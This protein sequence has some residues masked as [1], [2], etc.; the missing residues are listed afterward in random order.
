[1]RTQN[2]NARLYV[3]L[4]GDR[5][6]TVVYLHG[7][8]SSARTWS[9]LPTG[10]TAGRVTMRVD[11]RGH[12]RSDRSSRYDV[13]GIGSDILA[14]L[15]AYAPPR[16]VTFVGHSLGGVVAWW[17]AQCHPHRVAAALLVDPPLLLGSRDEFGRSTFHTTFSRL[18]MGIGDLRASGLTAEGI[19]KQIGWLP[20][21]RDPVVPLREHISEDA[22]EAMAFSYRWLDLAV[23]D[24]VLNGQMMAGFD[25][26]RPLGA[27]VIVLRAEHGAALTAEHALRLADLHPA[28]DIVT[29]AG[30]GHGMHEE[31][32]ARP[33]FTEYLA[34]FLAQH[35]P[36]DDRVAAAARV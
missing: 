16:P 34:E 6:P 10:V 9:W 36:I 3:E 31:R 21:S 27:P 28:V 22:L 14:A 17:V 4:E 19:A 13:P 23:L 5:G 18:R 32:A 12:G 20:V 15:D 30:S 7:A 1:M 25:P 2:S 26:A 8:G 35:A 29:V 11:L 33:V 24:S